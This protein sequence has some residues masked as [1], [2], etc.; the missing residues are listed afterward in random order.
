MDNNDLRWLEFKKYLLWTKNNK[1]S[2]H[3][4]FKSFR[5]LLYSIAAYNTK[6]LYKKKTF[7]LKKKMIATHRIEKYNQF[8][9]FILQRS[10]LSSLAYTTLCSYYTQHNLIT[11][12]NGRC[13]LKTL[14][15]FFSFVRGQ[16]SLG[17]ICSC[18]RSQPKLNI[19]IGRR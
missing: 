11:N 2:I 19:R 15:F 10:Y 9:F 8:F 1:N 3:V 6:R 17:L 7:N 5:V 16:F 14:I 12:N 13:F 18:W 4:S